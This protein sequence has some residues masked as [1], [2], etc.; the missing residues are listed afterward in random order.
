[1]KSLVL[2]LL[3]LMAVAAAGA[4]VMTEALSAANEPT[5]RAAPGG[6]QTGPGTERS[7][8][9]AIAFARAAAPAVVQ[10]KSS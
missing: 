4:A 5:Q 9:T 2:L 7:A 10:E 8:D 3:A 1:V 6:V